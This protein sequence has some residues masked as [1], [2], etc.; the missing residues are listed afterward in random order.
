MSSKLGVLTAIAEADAYDREKAEDIRADFIARGILVPNAEAARAAVSEDEQGGTAEAS[1]TTDVRDRARQEIRSRAAA[2]LPELSGKQIGKLF[3]FSER[4]GRDRIAEVRR[5]EPAASPVAAAASLDVDAAS[6]AA[7]TAPIPA[8]QLPPA[9]PAEGG[10][11]PAET[12]AAEAASETDPEPRKRPRSWPVL[13]LALPAFVAIW[14]GWVGLGELTGFGPVNLLPG[15]GGGWTL[16]TAIT[17]PIGVEAYA[18]FA[19]RVWLS[20]IAPTR[21]ARLFAMWS[22]IGSLV[23]GMAGQAAYHLMIAAG[24]TA[25]PWQITAFVSCLPVVVLG[26]GAA[27]AHLLHNGQR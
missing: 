19:L 10:S 1:E 9:A 22:A 4:W 6:S 26:C 24:W 27:L 7:N 18:A 16:N 5:S 12:P 8:P 25:A 17:L 20:G 23:L 3:G 11:A 2:G 15:I 21:T 13:L 14:G